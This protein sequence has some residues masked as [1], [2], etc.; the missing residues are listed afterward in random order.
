M[1]LVSE[2]DGPWEEA[3]EP[4]GPQEQ[5]FDTQSPVPR[6]L[7][8]PETCQPG[9]YGLS[10]EATERIRMEG[11]LFAKAIVR[12]PWAY[13]PP[14]DDRRQPED[15]TEPETD[16]IVQWASELNPE[17]SIQSDTEQGQIT[18]KEDD[19]E[20]FPDF[21]NIDWVEADPRV[22][23]ITDIPGD[24]AEGYRTGT[25][26]VDME[27]QEDP[28]E[29]ANVET[30]SPPNGEKTITL[31]PQQKTLLELL[32][33][34]A[35]EPSP[36][37]QSERAPG[38]AELHVSAK[39]VHAEAEIQDDLVETTAKEIQPDPKAE[40][41]GAEASKIRPRAL[42][43]PLETI[44][45]EPP[46]IEQDEASPRDVDIHLPTEVP[47]G[48]G[49]NVEIQDQEVECEL[50]KSEESRKSRAVAL[51]PGS[52]VKTPFSLDDIEAVKAAEKDSAYG[53]DDESDNA[54]SPLAQVEN[55]EVSSMHMKS[56]VHTH[57]H[58][59]KSR[60]KG[61]EHAVGFSCTQSKVQEEASASPG[62][63]LPQPHYTKEHVSH[64]TK[65]EPESKS[66]ELAKVDIREQL[67]QPEST[68]EDKH[69]G[70]QS[71]D[72]AEKFAK[73]APED[74]ISNI[75]LKN[76]DSTAPTQKEAEQDERTYFRPVIVTSEDKF[77][78]YNI[79]VQ[80][81]VKR[82]EKPE[83]KG[84]QRAL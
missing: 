28:G 35:K 81:R 51:H 83:T 50:A 4:D 82:V 66:A 57:S 7:L 42:K 31:D 56:V 10:D 6:V 73:D 45:E 38:D 25:T 54:Q 15:M 75:G 53:G 21:H 62:S 72:F 80:R 20:P 36:T 40:E 65:S 69:L 52:R 23:G 5:I 71:R 46:R 67:E 29:P 70:M 79:R 44:F 33:G 58:A 34:T 64:V 30:G 74:A 12:L 76:E 41:F 59:D 60:G 43:L 32:K 3:F 17:D 37:K 63:N 27:A 61:H 78:V 9:I 18:E 2:S 11:R 1:S 22:E 84:A 19:L 8:P 49:K 55:R 47:K 77:S 48:E 68:V 26:S 24:M 14:V 16:A 39:N 13:D